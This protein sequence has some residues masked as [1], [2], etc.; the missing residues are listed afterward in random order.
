MEKMKKTKHGGVR[1]GAGPKNKYSE[2]TTTIAFRVPVSK[3]EVIKKLVNQKL[4]E[5]KR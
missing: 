2:E 4:H 1:E 3:K 5:F